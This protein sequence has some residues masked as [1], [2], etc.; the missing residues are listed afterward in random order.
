MTD[1]AKE[2]LLRLHRALSKDLADKAEKNQLTPAEL[3]EARQ[4][5]LDNK[6][7]VDA[8][9]HAA[10]NKE[11]LPGLPFRMVD[12]EGGSEYV[13]PDITPKITWQA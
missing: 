5:L 10:P 2:D 13:D 9:G 12:E 3:K 1:Q 6:I 11:F 8:P 7:R 4:L